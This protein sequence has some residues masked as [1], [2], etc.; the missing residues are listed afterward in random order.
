MLG[1]IGGVLLGIV[2]TTGPASAGF[3][4]KTIGV[5]A[6]FPDQG[7]VCCGSEQ[8]VV[9]N[10]VEFP[11]GSF[12]LYSGLAFVDIFDTQIE[13]GQ[14]EAT[15]Y[16]VA[17]FNGF[18]F[19]DALDDI[20]AITNVSINA[21][22]NLSG[23]DASRVSFDADNV[24]INLQG[25]FADSAHHVVLDVTFGPASAVPEP[26]TLVLVMAALGGL[27]VRHPRRAR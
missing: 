27:A 7:T 15:S 5:D 4:G 14:T 6:R 19:F 22:T 12:P 26:G 11:A 13:Y 2:L 8:A 1:C 9:S 17:A 20:D 21:A 3:L 23:F 10:V 18:R 25:L 16:T 24:F